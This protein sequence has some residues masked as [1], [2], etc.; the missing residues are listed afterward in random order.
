MGIQGAGNGNRTRAF[1]LGSKCATANTMPAL[2]YFSV[3]APACL[4]SR[5]FASEFGA[6]TEIFVAGPF[7][8]L[9]ASLAPDYTDAGTQLSS[10]PLGS[11]PEANVSWIFDPAPDGI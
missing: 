9:K 6:P 5:R 8:D 7:V 1:C 3:L 4:G 2:F 11:S 10:N